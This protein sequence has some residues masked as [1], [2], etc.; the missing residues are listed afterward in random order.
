MCE[1]KR[2]Q[3]EQGE[4]GVQLGF[5]AFLKFYE[6]MQGSIKLKKVDDFIKSPYYR[7]FVKFGRYCVG[8]RAIAPENYLQWLLQKNKKIDR[9]NSDQLYTEFLIQYLQKEK[10]DDAL[11][12]AVEWSLTW[13]EKYS[14]PACDCLRYG[15]SNT[16]CYAITTG[17][18]SAWIIYNCESGR[19][20]LESLSPEQLAMIWPYVDTDAWQIKFQNYQSD[21]IFLSNLL[22][23]LGW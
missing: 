10:V 17:H 7:A 8:V 15:N 3:Q 12:R 18:L 6:T 22:Q 20:F 2:R 16:I 11:H 4:R 13:E 9:W 19:K 5:Y 23:E 1:P 14:N 21:Q